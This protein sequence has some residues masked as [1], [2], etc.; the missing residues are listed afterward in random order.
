MCGCSF[1]AMLCTLPSQQAQ[2]STRAATTELLHEQSS[3]A[4]IWMHG[5][6]CIIDAQGSKRLHKRGEQVLTQAA[7]RQLL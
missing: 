4:S 5:V 3:L 1:A 6:H 7:A 2:L